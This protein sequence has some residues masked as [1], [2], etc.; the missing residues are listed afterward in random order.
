MQQSTGGKGGGAATA[1]GSTALYHRQ[2]GHRPTAEEK[3]PA[4]QDLANAPTRHQRWYPSSTAAGV[5]YNNWLPT[6]D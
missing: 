3:R 1:S 6:C 2:R 4:S 5:S